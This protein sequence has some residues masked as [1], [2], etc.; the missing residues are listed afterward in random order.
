MAT[1]AGA[2]SAGAGI[3]PAVAVSDVFIVFLLRGL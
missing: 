1:F 2:W 3:T